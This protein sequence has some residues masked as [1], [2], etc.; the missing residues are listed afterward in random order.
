MRARTIPAAARLA[1]RREQAR[2]QWR[3]ALSAIRKSATSSDYARIQARLDAA[4]AE[5]ERRYLRAG[6]RRWG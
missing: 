2:V 5:N 3:A 4:K 1:G 6:G